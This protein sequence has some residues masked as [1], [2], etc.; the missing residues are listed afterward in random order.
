MWKINTKCFQVNQKCCSS[1]S[2]KVKNKTVLKK[3]LMFNVQWPKIFVFVLLLFTRILYE[4]MSKT[5]KDFRTTTSIIN[6]NNNYLKSLK[7]FYVTFGLFWGSLL[8]HLISFSNK[9]I[10]ISLHQLYIIINYGINSPSFIL[11]TSI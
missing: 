10:W 5:I 1:T 7:L 8:Y 4:I 3:M 11:S 9:I 2:K 6:I